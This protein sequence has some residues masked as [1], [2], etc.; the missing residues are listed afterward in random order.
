MKK[1]ILRECIRIAQEKKDAHPYNKKPNLRHFTFVIHNNKIL[2]VGKNRPD[3]AWTEH[4]Y[5]ALSGR[6]SEVDGWLKAKGLLKG[7]SFEVINIRVHAHGRIM[8]SK[9]CECCYRF[10]A[11]M[12]CTAAYFSTGI[13]SMDFARLSLISAH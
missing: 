13:D 5:P 2:A 4:G 11:S 1:T 3:E 12:G 10:L 9:P 8:N 6:H 7:A